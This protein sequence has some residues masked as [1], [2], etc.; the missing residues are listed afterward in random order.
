M[1]TD[2]IDNHFMVFYTAIDRDHLHFP[3][4]FENGKLS[5][6][7][8]ELREGKFCFLHSMKVLTCAVYHSRI[9]CYFSIAFSVSQLSDFGKTVTLKIE[10][11]NFN[12]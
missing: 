1:A 12:Y 5:I 3:F 6:R 2:E 4:Y 9:V 7:Q 10:T 8:N 11:F